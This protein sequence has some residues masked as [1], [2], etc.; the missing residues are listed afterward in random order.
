[1]RRILPYRSRER[2]VRLGLGCSQRPTCSYPCPS[3][4]PHCL[5]GFHQLKS[6]SS[7]CGS[8]LSHRSLLRQ[9]LSHTRASSMFKWQ[10]GRTAE[11][12]TRWRE[13]EIGAKRT[14]HAFEAPRLQT[15]SLNLCNDGLS[16]TLRLSA[17][18]F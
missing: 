2:R 8:S 4:M 5:S 10:L 9:A 1:M 18:V 12:T 3:W 6:C 11:V 15:S 16:S 7:S 17:A 14:L 13:C